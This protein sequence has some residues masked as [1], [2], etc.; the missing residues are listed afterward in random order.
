[1]LTHPVLDPRAW[2]AE[3]VDHPD[4]WYYPLSERPLAA[5]DQALGEG[6]GP[7]PVT[8][9]RAPAGL[10]A[11]VEKDLQPV[12]TALEEGRG[13]VVL[14]P[15]APGRFAPQDLPAVYWLVGQVLG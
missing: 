14:T 11:A 13:F 10:R 9:P 12:R 15:G 3:T 8:E 1:M 2:Q 6:Q 5:L 4:T 7:Q